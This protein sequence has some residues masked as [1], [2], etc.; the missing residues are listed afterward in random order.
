MKRYLLIFLFSLYSLLTFGQEVIAQFENS[1]AKNDWGIKDIVP[2]VNQKNGDISIFI[3]DA[4]KVYAYHLN[5][6][7]EVEDKMVV[8]DKARKYKLIIGNSIADNGD[9]RIFLSNNKKDEFATINF[10][11]AGKTSDI[12]EFELQSPKELFIQTISHENRFYM[13]SIAKKTSLLGLYIFDEQGNATRRSIDFSNENF[14]DEDGKQTTIYDLIVNTQGFGTNADITKID[15]DNPNTIESTSEFTKFYIR[16]NKAVFTFD[17][18]KDITQLISFDINTFTTEA[19]QFAKPLPNIKA[20][21][22]KTNSYIYGDHIFMLS[23]T[24]EIVVFTVND[25]ATGNLIKEYSATENDSITFKNSPIIQVGGFYDGY[26]EMEKTKKFIRKIN[27][28]DVGISIYRFDDNY[29]VT[30]G[31]KLEVKASGGGMM[32]GMPGVGIGSFGAVTVYFN[33]TY[34]AY[35]S[36]TNT[37][38]TYIECLFNTN[39]DHLEGE[40]KDNVFDKIHDFEEAQYISEKATTIFK[41]KDVFILGNLILEGNLYRLRKFND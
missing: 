22:K 27:S 29:Q 37:K 16:N 32:M 13:L 1:L 20:N 8:E 39:F 30:L 26:R 5:D 40:P 10:S 11:F 12:K 3:A 34:F 7:F 9:Y 35:N 23:S 18:N 14:I 4:K 33:P 2:I 36:Y 41:Y 15:E 28:G 17:Q 25:F 6:L 19:K 21:K 38:S 24:D 31:G